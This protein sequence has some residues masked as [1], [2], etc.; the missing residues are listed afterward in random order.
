M[1]KKTSSEKPATIV[2]EN[3]LT[4]PNKRRQRWLVYGAIVVVTFLIVSY[5]IWHVSMIKEDVESEYTAAVTPIPA[6]PTPASPSADFV[7]YNDLSG[8]EKFA[9]AST[10]F[11]PLL[12]ASFAYPSGYFVTSYKADKEDPTAGIYFTKN[13][14]DLETMRYVVDC[15]LD[16]RKDPIGM[17]VEGAVGDIEVHMSTLQK[18]TYAPDGKFIADTR[19]GCFKEIDTKNRVLYACETQLSIDARDKGMEYLVYLFGDNPIVIRVTSRNPKEHAHMIRSII[20][21]AT[22]HH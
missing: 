19:D 3:M 8:E 7:F 17:C 16:N 18:E 2:P 10:F 13:A 22:N 11:D 4:T 20:S 9:V 6:T 12:K 14:K 1:E 5:G 15:T 21:S